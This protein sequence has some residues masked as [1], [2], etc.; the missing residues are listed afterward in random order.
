MP[1][2]EDKPP[3]LHSVYALSK[4]DQERLCLTIGEAYDIPTVALRF[5][6][7]YGPRQ[8]LSNP[9]TGGLAIF[10]SRL[11]HDQPPRIFEDGAQM[12]D[13]VSVHDVARACRLALEKDTGPA[14]LNIGS[15]SPRTVREV[16]ERM[17][18]ALAR[19]IAPVITNQ[20][21]KGDIRH[22]FADI[23]RARDVLGYE[24]RIAF[25][26]GLQELAGWLAVQVSED[27]TEAAS[28]ELAERGLVV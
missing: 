24:P 20:W 10:A 4:F 17:A 3:A 21:R 23:A 15:G 7:V 6:N 26:D 14:V 2:S 19:P 27:R 9:Y 16:S 1:T 13:F 12:R 28:R 8:A 22:C 25:D 18:A 5:F 11:L